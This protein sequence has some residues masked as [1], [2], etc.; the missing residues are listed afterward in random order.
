[1]SVIRFKREYR[2]NQPGATDDK[3]TYGMHDAL[4][5]RGV[6]EWVDQSPLAVSASQPV[7]AAPETTH[8]RKPRRFSKESL[9]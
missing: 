8:D 1:M 2:R 9:T 5:C 7:T 4:V 6:A 3:M